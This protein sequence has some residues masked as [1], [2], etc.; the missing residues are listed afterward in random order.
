MTTLHRPVPVGNYEVLQ[1]FER[2]N[3]GVRVLRLKRGT[4][5]IE[6]HTHQRSMQMYVA[7]EG[8]VTVHIDGEQTLLQPYQAVPIWPG[9]AHSAEATMEDA[10]LLNISLPAL[11]AEDQLP[12]GITPE[13]PDF[14]LPHDTDDIDD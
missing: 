14:A 2:P 6:G 7:I 9:S 4:G 3:V 10:V 8:G 11:S 13:P 1:D 12:I 5:A